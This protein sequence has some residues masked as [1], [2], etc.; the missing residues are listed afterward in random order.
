M[1][2]PVVE[3]SMGG[4]RVI[5][6]HKRDD[7]RETATPRKVVDPAQLQVLHAAD[8]IA[9][10]WVT[11]TRMEHVVDHLRARGIVLGPA[12]TK[13]VIDEMIADVVREGRLEIVDS[14]EARKAIGSRAAR[15][16]KAWQAKANRKHQGEP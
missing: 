4:E 6:K 10:E 12:A 8:A 15:L 7:E 11:D 2:R 5:A 3:C 13:A 16:F 9:M 14:P 1:L